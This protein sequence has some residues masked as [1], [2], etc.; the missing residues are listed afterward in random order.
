MEQL[1]WL[2]VVRH[3]QST[4]NVI[5]QAAETGGAE[6]ID[7]E[8]RDADEVRTLAG[9]PTTVPDTP[10]YNP[11]FDVTPAPLLAA[12]VTEAATFRAGA[13]TPSPDGVAAGAR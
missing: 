8:E 5:A 4:G 7:I 13:W 1:Q 2:G 3:G 10:V 11:A 9:V 12:V 6:V